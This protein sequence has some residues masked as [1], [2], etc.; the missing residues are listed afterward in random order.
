MTSNANI[1][2]NGSTPGISES[3]RLFTSISAFVK[4]ASQ[5]NTEW[6]LVI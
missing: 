2:A 4:A 3:Q 1:A 6:K 5:K